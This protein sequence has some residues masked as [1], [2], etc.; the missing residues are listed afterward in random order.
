MS[1]S[2]SSKGI[3]SLG[4]P[5]IGLKK[6]LQILCAS[7]L[8][9]HPGTGRPDKYPQTRELVIAGTPYIVPYQI[10]GERISII[11]VLHGAMK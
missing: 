11:R 5:S 2:V 9:Q 6:Y 8:S 3:T 10:T 1:Y 4:E 7:N